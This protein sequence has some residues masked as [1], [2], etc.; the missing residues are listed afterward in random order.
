M[1]NW[2]QHTKLTFHG[3]NNFDVSHEWLLSFWRITLNFVA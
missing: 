2:T 3:E 1:A